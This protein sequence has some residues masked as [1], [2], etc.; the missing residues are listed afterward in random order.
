MAAPERFAKKSDFSLAPRAPSIHRPDR[1]YTALHKYGRYRG[2]CGHAAPAVRAIA[3]RPEM[4]ALSPRNSRR[5]QLSW[6]YFSTQSAHFATLPIPHGMIG[7]EDVEFF[8]D[9]SMILSLYTM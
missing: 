8:G 3:E 1:R 2:C 6:H 9:P 7:T 5:S 4:T